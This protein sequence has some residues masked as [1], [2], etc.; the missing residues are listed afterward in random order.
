MTIHRMRME[1]EV[2]DATIDALLSA[3]YEIQVESGDDVELEASRN[4]E[5]IT[6][7]LFAKNDKGYW[8]CNYDEAALLVRIAGT[9]AFTSFVAFVFGNYGWDVIHDY[10][11]SL[12]DALLP[13]MEICDRLEYENT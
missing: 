4:K 1:K 12:E 9:D 11:V 10:G 3:G 6:G 7:T 2:V 8:V 13:V 5:D